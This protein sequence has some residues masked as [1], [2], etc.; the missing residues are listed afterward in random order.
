MKLLEGS[1][2]LTYATDDIKDGLWDDVFH[3]L[4]NAGTRAEFRTLSMIYVGLFC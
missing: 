3:N 2:S 1:K 4:L